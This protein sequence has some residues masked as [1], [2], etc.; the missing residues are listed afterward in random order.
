MKIVIKNAFMIHVLRPGE[1]HGQHFELKRE[2]ESRT[3]ALRILRYYSD[4]EQR[5][6]VILKITK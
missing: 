2:R 3:K 6:L 5:Y 4:K 1:H